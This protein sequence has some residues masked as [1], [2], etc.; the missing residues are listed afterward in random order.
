MK[1]ELHRIVTYCLWS[2]N[3]CFIAGMYLLFGLMIRWMCLLYL[4]VMDI[5]VKII[6][7][8]AKCPW[9]VLNCL[10]A[11]QCVEAY[12][13]SPIRFLLRRRLSQ[14]QLVLWWQRVCGKQ[15]WFPHGKLAEDLLVTELQ[16]SFCS[17]TP[18][19]SPAAPGTLET[20]GKL[21]NHAV[22]FEIWEG[23]Q[24]PL[25]LKAK[26]LTWKNILLFFLVWCRFPH[27]S[28]FCL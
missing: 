1:A 5:Y 11:L 20:E 2:S 16:F 7:M 6:F 10:W 28:V 17:H 26:H 18:S 25:W 21:Q 8:N 22:V 12:L 4:L 27:I 14:W 9:M 19:P 13:C 15:P 3:M 24:P 23:R